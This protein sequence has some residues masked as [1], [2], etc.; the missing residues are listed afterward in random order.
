MTYREEFPDF[1]FTVP[2]CVTTDWGFEDVSWGG[3][4]NPS[5]ECDVFMLQVDYTDRAKREFPEWKQFTIT[6]EGES[7]LE[8]DSWEDVRA[9]VEDGKRHF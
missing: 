7:M 1:D 8:T 4:T 6:C 3:D 5:F 2:A 9:F